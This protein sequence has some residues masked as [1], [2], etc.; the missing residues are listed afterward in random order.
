MINLAGLWKLVKFHLDK[1]W[2]KCPGKPL[3]TVTS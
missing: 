1:G 2:F 3:K